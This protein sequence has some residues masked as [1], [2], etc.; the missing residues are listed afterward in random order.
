M[1]ATLSAQTNPPAS[2]AEAPSS[3]S[4]VALDAESSTVATQCHA[5]SNVLPAAAAP[6]LPALPEPS[7]IETS[8]AAN[9]NPLLLEK[10]AAA[11]VSPIH[12]HMFVAAEQNIFRLLETDSFQRFRVHWSAACA[13]ASAA[14][15]AAAP[16]PQ[17][18]K[19]ASLFG[20]F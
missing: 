11:A 18:K 16:K 9:S 2:V 6:A 1:A 19:R 12:A 8:N 14:V 13:E 3:S 15:A 7:A 17:L 5:A 10:S 4:C 20:M